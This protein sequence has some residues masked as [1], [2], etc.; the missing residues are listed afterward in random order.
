[1]MMMIR[2]KDSRQ[3]LQ[4]APPA[5]GVGFLINMLRQ[6]TII[7]APLSKS[8][9]LR[10]HAWFLSFFIPT[11]SSRRLNFS[12]SPCSLSPCRSQTLATNISPFTTEEEAQL[13]WAV[14]F[15][16][17]KWADILRAGLFPGRSYKQLQTKW[18]NNGG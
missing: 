12:L 14:Q 17:E 2:S 1:M 6:E 4:H 9:S 7:V 10:A 13:C 15:F 16:G 5:T 8:I 18:T 3:A 11:F